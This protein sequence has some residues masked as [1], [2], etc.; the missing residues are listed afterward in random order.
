MHR[1]LSIRSALLPTLLLAIGPAPAHGMCVA[2]PT[3]VLTVRV[4]SC[5]ASLD[6][7]ERTRSTEDSSD[8]FGERIRETVEGQPGVVVTGTATQTVEVAGGPDGFT[9]L[10]ESREIER[11]GE[12]FIALDRLEPAD[13]DAPCDAYPAGEITQIY[14]PP[15]CCDMLPPQD[16][17]CA[18]G[19]EAGAPVPEELLSLLRDR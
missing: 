8:V 17:P 7:W 5:E 14:V 1:H 10:G 6:R 15:I 2:A 19:V 4:A 13:G 9:A 3:Q 18:L 11:E 16:A 12:W